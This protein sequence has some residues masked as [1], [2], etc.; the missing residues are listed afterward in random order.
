MYCLKWKNAPNLWRGTREHSKTN[1]MYKILSFGRSC[2]SYLRLYE[3]RCPDVKLCCEGC[4]HWMHKHGHY[5]RSVISKCELIR[6]PIYR[7]FCP[8]CKNTVSLLP[9]FLVPSARFTTWVRE[10]AIS[11]KFQGR[12]Y[13]KISETVT[14][15][16]MRVSRSTIKRWWTQHLNRAS[17]LSLWI[18]KQLAERNH[19]EDLFDIYPKQMNASPFETTQWLRQLIP[20]YCRKPSSVRGYWSWLN[21]HTPP[22]GYL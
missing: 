13:R 18:A 15:T 6:I 21:A 17:H 2:K 16:I 22:N 12:S 9:D 3:T 11:R 14:A 8:R 19:N 10:A 7:W 20:L 4:G 1:Y 5:L